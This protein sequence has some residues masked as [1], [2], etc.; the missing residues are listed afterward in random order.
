MTQHI[1]ELVLIA[2]PAFGLAWFAAQGVAQFIGNQVV[3]QAAESTARQQAQQLG[4][5]LGADQE[6]ALSGKTLDHV[7]VMLDLGQ[8]GL[9]CGISLALIC[10]AVLIASV[11]T[12]RAKPKALLTQLS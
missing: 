8:W 1:L 12:L 4:S 5:N 11:P 10:V 6:S 7:Q 3:S 2:I 9:V